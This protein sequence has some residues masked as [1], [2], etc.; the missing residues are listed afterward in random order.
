MFVYITSKPIDLDQTRMRWI[1]I[2][3]VGKK[4]SI[5]ENKTFSRQLSVALINFILTIFIIT[6]KIPS[7]RKRK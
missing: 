2:N 4:K 7:S 1:R 6:M 3:S 5:R